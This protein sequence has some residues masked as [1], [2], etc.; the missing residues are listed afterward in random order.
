MDSAISLYIGEEGPVWIKVEELDYKGT[1]TK[2]Y[3]RFSYVKGEGATME[4]W[5]GEYSEYDFWEIE[6]PENTDYIRT[7]FVNGAEV[8]YEEYRKEDVK[9]RKMRYVVTVQ[10]CNYS[11]PEGWD[12]ACSQLSV[13][14]K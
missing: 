12:E 1:A 3:Y 8:S 4:S 14:R 6:T 10:L 7:Y 13:L 9:R 2:D 11:Y 5:L